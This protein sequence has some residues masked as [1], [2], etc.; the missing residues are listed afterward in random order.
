MDMDYANRR[1]AYVQEVRDSF[2]EENRLA[3]QR[4]Q[5]GDGFFTFFKLRLLVAV[6]LFAAFFGCLSTGTEIAGYSAEEVMALVCDNHYYTN[7]KNYVMIQE[8]SE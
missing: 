6:M 8:Q 2:R 4:E 5:A 1:R 7:L 3:E